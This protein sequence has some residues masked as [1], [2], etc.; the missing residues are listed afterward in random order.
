MTCMV[1]VMSIHGMRYNT[2]VSK[3]GGYIALIESKGET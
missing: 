1:V 2:K 3:F